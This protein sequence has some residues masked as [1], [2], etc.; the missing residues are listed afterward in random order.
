VSEIQVVS[1]NAI[2][3]LRALEPDSLGPQLG[4]QRDFRWNALLREFMPAPST[5]SVSWVRL[6]CGEVL[7]PQVQP[8]QSLLVFYAGNGV[9]VGDLERPVSKDDVVIMPAGCEYGAIGGKQGLQGLSIQFGQGSYAAATKARADTTEPEHRLE[10]LLAYNQQRLEE[11]RRRPLFSLIDDGT[12]RDR[13]KRQAFLDTLQVWLD[14]QEALL[15]A[16]QASCADPDYAGAF[17]ED[18]RHRTERRG[19]NKGRSEAGGGIGTKND[20]VVE[21]ITEWFTYQMFV[22]DNAEKAAVFYLVIELANTALGS[23][24]ATLGREVGGFRPARLEDDT[25]RAAVA[26]ELLR[27]QSA[28]IYARLRRIVGEAWDMFSALSDRVVEVTLRA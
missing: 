20:V 1:R 3:P 11:F 28:R 5:F 14:G 17:H 6:K 10:S 2:P 27:R 9:I 4:E 7:T 21:A 22:L 18:V 16:R 15:F 13:F 12:L 23:S 25:K 19:T 8:M 26:E 24:L